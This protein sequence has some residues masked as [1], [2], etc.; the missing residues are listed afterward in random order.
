VL[1]RVSY[2]PSEPVASDWRSGWL[3]SQNVRPTFEPSRIFSTFASSVFTWSDALLS[4]LES[5]RNFVNGSGSLAWSMLVDMGFRLGLPAGSAPVRGL[6]EA[7]PVQGP[8]QTPPQL[9]GLGGGGR[10]ISTLFF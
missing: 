7:R 4:C 9:S 5:L 8:P 3:S 2:G 1:S 6:C 10:T